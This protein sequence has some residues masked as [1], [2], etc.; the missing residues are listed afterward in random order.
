MCCAKVALD[1]HRADRPDPPE[2]R[3]PLGM[4]NSECA[5]AL[6]SCSRSTIYPPK[7][8]LDIWQS[9]AYRVNLKYICNQGLETM[10]IRSPDEVKE[11]F[12]KEIEG[13]LDFYKSTMRKLKIKSDQNR[14]ASQTLM[15]AA[16]IW[17]C[18]LHELVIAYIRKKPD[19]FIDHLESA[20]DSQQSDKQKVIRKKYAPFCRPRSINTDDIVKIIDIDEKNIIFTHSSELGTKAK[21]W[22]SEEHRRGFIGITQQK[23]A[24]ID[25]VISLR[26]CIAHGSES[27][28]KKLRDAVNNSHIS[29]YD[30]DRKKYGINDHGAY[31]NS[32]KKGGRRV[33]IIIKV[34]KEIGEKL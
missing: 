13:I 8:F 4:E 11:V 33:E 20:L 17:E 24:V 10:P 6:E 28:L 27:S 18:F 26:N 14:L 31:L 21:R 22:I 3:R 23:K 9:L 7:T 2:K 29:C 5:K 15:S 12:N 16:T 25:L 19:R 34:M 30:L 32:K 1:R